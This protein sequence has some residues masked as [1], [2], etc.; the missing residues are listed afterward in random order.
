MDNCN[1][2]QAP[3][4]TDDEVA[5]MIRAIPEHY[6]AGLVVDLGNTCQSLPSL[7]GAVTQSP[8]GQLCG[9]SGI[10]VGD[11]IDMRDSDTLCNV[12]MAGTAVLSSG[13]AI[14]QVQTADATTSGTFTDPTSGLG[15]LPSV[16]QSGGNIWLNSGSFAGIYGSGTSGQFVTSGFCAF[17]S[18]QRPHRYARLLFNSGFYIGPLQA[19]FV[20]QLKTTGSGGGFTFAPGSG[21]VS[22]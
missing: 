6:S 20:S 5:R 2:W 13:P 3:V 12:Y 4:I 17:A 19:G 7:P 10:L 1:L 21:T 14:I 9:L 22:V 15:R 11:I 16:F 8:S 18:F